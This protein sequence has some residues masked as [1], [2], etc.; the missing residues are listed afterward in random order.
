MNAR[1]PR[2]P[3][4]VILTGP[5]VT[6]E[7]DHTSQTAAYALIGA[8]LGNGSPATEARVMQWAD[9]RWWHFETVRAGDLT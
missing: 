4:R 1:R 7:S 5:D 8:A 6:A 3:W 9:G 2:R